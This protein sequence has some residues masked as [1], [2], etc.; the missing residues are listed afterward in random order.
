[1]WERVNFLELCKT[2]SLFTDD[3][4]SMGAGIVKPQPDGRGGIRIHIN[5][6]NH[7]T[8]PQ[9]SN[10]PFN[11]STNNGNRPPAKPE[12]TSC[13]ECTLSFTAFRRKVCTGLTH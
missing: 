10:Q 12:P 7:H 2:V 8:S 1:M 3:Q 9:F 11:S 6:G 5:P 13:E 4:G